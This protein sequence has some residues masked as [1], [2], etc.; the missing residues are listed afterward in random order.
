M[1]WLYKDSEELEDALLS[2]Y[3][4]KL[5]LNSVEQIPVEHR[6]PRDL[7]FLGV[8]H[9]SLGELYKE[10][11][12]VKDLYKARFHMEKAAYAIKAI[13]GDERTSWMRDILEEI[14]NR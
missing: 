5:A 11:N 3:H 8:T 10:V 2:I 13:P 14:N 9:Y 4:W 6:D 7:Y 1:G 12:K